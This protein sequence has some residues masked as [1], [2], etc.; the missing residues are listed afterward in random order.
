LTATQDEMLK[1]KIATAS[2]DVGKFL[3]DRF[4]RAARSA[5]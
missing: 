1:Y 3:D 2:V 4:A 5:K